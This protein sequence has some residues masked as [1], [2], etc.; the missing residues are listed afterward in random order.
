[1]HPHWHSASPSLQRKLISVYLS[2]ASGSASASPALASFQDELVYADPR[3]VAAV[4]RWAI[5]HFEPTGGSTFGGDDAYVWYTT[6]ARA[7]RERGYPQDAFDSALTLPVQHAA[8]LTAVLDLTCSLAAHAEANGISGAKFAKLVGRWLLANKRKAAP[9]DWHGFYA[10]WDR[11]G[12]ILEHLF[13]ARIRAQATVLP[14][15]LT[16]LV[17]GYPYGTPEGDLL[18][19]P[20]ASTRVYPALLVTID[21]ELPDRAGRPASVPRR[22]PLRIAADALSATPYAS[23]GD[24]VSAW[25]ALKAAARENGEPSPAHVFTDET[26]NLLSLVPL[27]SESAHP[28]LTVTVLSPHAPSPALSAERTQSSGSAN[29]PRSSLSVDASSGASSASPG[30][31]P[32]DALLHGARGQ[33][34]VTSAFSFTDWTEFQSLGFAESASAPGLAATLREADPYVEV[35]QPPSPVP[36]RSASPAGGVLGRTLSRRGS[37]KRTGSPGAKKTP[38]LSLDIGASEGG[39]ASASVAGTPRTAT[40]APATAE[41]PKPRT[42]QVTAVQLDEA[43]V[44]AWADALTDPAS[45]HGPQFVLAQLKAP[46]AGGASWVVLER[47][48]TRPAPP[49]R[50]L[51]TGSTTPPSA[52]RKTAVAASPRPSLSNERASSASGKRRF[53]LFGRS[54]SGDKEKERAGKGKERERARS[55]IAERVGEMGEILEDPKA[56]AAAVV[57]VVGAAAVGAVAAVSG[58]VDAN[59]VWSAV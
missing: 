53:G 23:G 11:A 43:F 32:V 34:T 1:M 33:P 58:K 13:L 19:K 40:P 25:E 31:S 41:E 56:A 42:T 39:S 49:P 35:T 16:T 14:K 26:L 3:D 38:R 2:H 45:A 59:Q 55:P 22:H 29:P 28:A 46:L 50:A 48:F 4:L 47:T 24:T 52:Q 20:R 9:D 8:L 36:A 37:G 57:G 7:E 15:R 30:K 18:A 44:D 54:L 10:D 51:A 27:T 12:R 17:V 6:F 21:S 5:R